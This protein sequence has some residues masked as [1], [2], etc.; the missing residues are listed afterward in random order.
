MPQLTKVAKQ[1]RFK[2]K[3]S[4][5]L[6]ETASSLGCFA[7]GILFINNSMTNLSETIWGCSTISQASCPRHRSSNTQHFTEDKLP[8]L[9]TLMIGRGIWPSLLD[10]YKLDVT[11]L[12]QL[13]KLHVCFIAPRNQMFRVT[14]YWL[15]TKRKAERTMSWKSDLCCDVLP[16]C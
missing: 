5:L 10:E 4:K 13:L 16:R 2:K 8:Q 3:Q 7:G 14:N 1:D 11:S 9:S 12:Q 6:R 15:N